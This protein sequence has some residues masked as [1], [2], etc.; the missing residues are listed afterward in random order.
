LHAMLADTN[1]IKLI[2]PAPLFLLDLQWWLGSS[3]ASPAALLLGSDRTPFLQQHFLRI[4]AEQGDELMAEAAT[5]NPPQY[6]ITRNFKN[7]TGQIS[8]MSKLNKNEEN[9]NN[10]DDNGAL[11][12]LEYVC[13]LRDK[14]RAYATIVDRCDSTAFH[15]QGNY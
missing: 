4:L 11:I 2:D 13:H 9:Y 6:P 3:L 7:G 14:R 12:V 8:I 5:T 1:E 10:G 15:R